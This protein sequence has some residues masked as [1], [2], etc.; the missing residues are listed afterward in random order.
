[1]TAA[2]P[3]SPSETDE[4]ALSLEEKALVDLGRALRAEYN[5]FV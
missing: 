3:K 1:M 5:E 4:A 2:L